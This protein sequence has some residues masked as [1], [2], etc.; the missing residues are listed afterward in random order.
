V[1]RLDPES[2]EARMDLGAAYLSIGK[3][4]EAEAVY[5][6]VLR[7]KPRS[8]AALKLAG[9]LARTRGDLKKAS[10]LYG[11]LRWVSPHDPRPACLLGTAYFEA[12]N[13]AAAER[14]FVDASKYPGMMG[15]AYG[16]LGVIAL[17]RGQPKEALWFLGRAAKRKPQRAV[18]RFNHAVAL[19]SNDR[20]SDALNELHAAQVLAPGDSGIHF[21][22][23]VIALRL[24]LLGEAERCFREALRLDPQNEDARHNL[25]LL[26]PLVRPTREDK[27]TLVGEPVPV[28][29]AK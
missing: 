17:K 19:Y 8:A 5:D 10:A 22:T 29:S 12:G 2:L 24:G 18:V 26:E 20:P 27:L 25:S 13:L 28:E 9:D 15:E 1:V 4:A 21:F 3:A 6:E 14:W 23:G 16:N 11:K 7:R